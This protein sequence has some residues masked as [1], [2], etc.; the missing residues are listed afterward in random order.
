MP[1]GW[2]QNSTTCNTFHNREPRFDIA[3]PPADDSGKY[4]FLLSSEV[5]EHVLPPAGAP[6]QNAFRVLKPHGFL[7]FTVPYSLELSMAEHFPDLHDFGLA[8]LRDRVLL[9]NRT[10]D[11]ATQVFDNLVFHRDG[12]GT[13]LEM[14]EF[15]EASLKR[16]SCMP[17]PVSRRYMSIAKIIRPSASCIPSPVPCP[18]P[19]VKLRS[20][21]VLRQPRE[22]V[23]GIPRTRSRSSIVE[24]QRLCGKILVPASKPQIGAIVTQA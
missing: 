14:R 8:S 21:L 9:I 5:F 19:R 22:V 16:H 1:I 11:G 17:P 2:L 4:D 18:L 20:R 23:E 12:S 3:N 15:S 10:R 6:F 24:M 13:A 7:V